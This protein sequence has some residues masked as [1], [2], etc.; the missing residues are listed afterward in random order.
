VGKDR[1]GPAV[2]GNQRSTFG[3]LL[4]A[5]LQA[6]VARSMIG[7]REVQAVEHGRRG[8]GLL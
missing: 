3:D 7:S 8:V 5:T 4:D 2:K 6:A 1:T